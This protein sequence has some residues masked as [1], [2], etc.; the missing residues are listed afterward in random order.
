MQIK[1]ALGKIVIRNLEESDVDS[2]AVLLC[3]SFAGREWQ[4]LEDVKCVMTPLQFVVTLMSSLEHATCIAKW[5][6]HQQPHTRLLRVGGVQI[7]PAHGM[8]AVSKFSR[9]GC[10]VVPRKYAT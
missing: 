8:C 6:C 7:V 3:R 5:Q 1:H 9:P 2:A 10:E 4:S